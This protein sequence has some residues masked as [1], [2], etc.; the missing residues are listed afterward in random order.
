MRTGMG[1]GAATAAR[2]MRLV[3]VN[4]D[5]SALVRLG[6]ALR[7]AG[8]TFVT[9]T[10][11]THERVNRR[12]GNAWADGMRDVFGWSR[13]FDEGVLPPSIVSLMI[14]AGIMGEQRSKL[15]VSTLDGRLFFHSAFPTRERD[16]VFFGPDS[17]R[18]AG[19]LLA[20][21]AVTEPIR[22][23]VDIGCGAG[24]GAVLIASAFPDADVFG[25][26]VNPVALKLTQVNAELAGVEVVACHSNILSGVPGEFDLIVANPPYLVDSAGRE[27]RHGGGPLG[28]ELSLAV[29]DQ[30]LD[31]MS[32]GGSL[33]LYTG[34][35]IVDGS[36]RFR[37]AAVARL[38]RSGC[39]WTYREL[40]PDVFGEEL[41]GGSYIE[42]DRIAAVVLT[43]KQTG[44]DDNA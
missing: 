37:D 1:C 7:E 31:R 6:I 22:R 21:L 24:P 9:P 14:E 13:P 5:R 36:D 35:A 33:V 12:S 16:A 4:I 43:A 3:R 15:R 29:L 40:D 27:Y 26:D 18:F 20:H 25:A 2:P 38:C 8:Y 28:A 41:D 17:Y 32:S 42:A 44:R 34:T 23:A 30:S 19:V 11:L 10:P 39:T